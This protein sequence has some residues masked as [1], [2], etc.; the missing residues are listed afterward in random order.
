MGHLYF[1]FGNKSIQ[2]LCPFKNQVVWLCDG[3]QPV[4]AIES[5]QWLL[6]KVGGMYDP[7]HGNCCSEW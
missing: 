7:S 4:M 1:L 2:I 3:L 5:E 6:G